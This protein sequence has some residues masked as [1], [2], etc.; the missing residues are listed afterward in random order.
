MLT[1]KHTT[2]CVSPGG[3]GLQYFLTGMCGHRSQYRPKFSVCL[4]HENY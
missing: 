2:S 4:A 1:V 3:G